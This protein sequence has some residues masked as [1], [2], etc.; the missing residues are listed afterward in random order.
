[1]HVRLLGTAAGG[2]FPQWNCN[3]GNCRGIRAGSVRARART[4]SCVALSVDGQRWFLLNVSPDIRS[5]IAA[6]SPLEPPLALQRGTSIEAAFLTDA[7]LDHALGLLLLREGSPFTVY[8][9]AA[10]QHAL[11]A[12]LTLAPTLACYSNMQ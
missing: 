12:G 2:G 1:M 6:F 10:M 4:Q 3:C 7:D 11:T 8:A 9:T 5:Q